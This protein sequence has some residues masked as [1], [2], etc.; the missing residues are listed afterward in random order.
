[1]GEPAGKSA[2]TL[3]EFLAWEAL[4]PER[5]EFVDG[6]IFAMSG[7]EERHVTTTLNVAMALRQHLVGGPCRALMLD[8]KLQVDERI[9]YPDVLVTCSP[10]DR[11]QSLV[12]REPVLIVEVLSH[13]TA[14]YDRGDKFSHYRRIESLRELA[15]IERVHGQAGRDVAGRGNV[16]LRARQM[17][18]LLET[19]VRFGQPSGGV[20]PPVEA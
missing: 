3:N 9:F 16:A 7:A 15:L 5:H 14:A 2:M 12:K 20:F 18:V 11:Q 1:M 6:D 19:R 8:M 17:P 10:A 13:S 4:Q